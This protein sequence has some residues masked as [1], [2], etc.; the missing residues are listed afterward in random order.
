M[1][2]EEIEYLHA[3]GKMPDRYYCAQNGKSP[4]FNMWEQRQKI[5]KKVREKQELKKQEQMMEGVL[6]EQIK[7]QLDKIFTRISK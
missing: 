5:I 4:E 7:K 2:L 1:T 6:D 3:T